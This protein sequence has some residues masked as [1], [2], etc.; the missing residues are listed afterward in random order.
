MDELL[1]HAWWMLALRGAAGVSF[2]LLALLWPGLTLLLL[3]AMFAAYA[4]VGGIASV[5]A[6]I[7]NRSTRT[8]WWVLLLLGLCSVAA[9]VIAMLLPGIT[10]LL[11]IAVIGANAVVTGVFD[12]ITAVRLRKR[13]R[14]EPLLFFIG[15]LSVVFGIVV[16]FYP[17]AGALA[18]VWV[19][20]TY[21]LITGALLLVF[22]MGARGW[23]R[24]DSSGKPNSPL[25]S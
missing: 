19:I 11:L 5:L 3:V 9:G 8:D 14:N 12:L 15:I 25:H 4:L 16:L 18:L 13:G 6:A 23:Q 24:A 1:G 7:K 10:A 21:A 2:S 20:S 17:G 22:A